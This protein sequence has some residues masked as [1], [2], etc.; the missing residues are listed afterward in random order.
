MIAIW[1][2]FSV[3]V[4]VQCDLR[5]FSGDCC[6]W[7]AM[8]GEGTGQDAGGHSWFPYILK[9]SFMQLVF[10]FVLARPSIVLNGRRGLN[11][12]E[13]QILYQICTY[14]LFYSGSKD[15]I[16]QFNKSSQNKSTTGW[17]IS[18]ITLH[19]SCQSLEIYLFDFPAKSLASSTTGRRRLRSGLTGRAFRVHIHI[20]NYHVLW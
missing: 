9:L 18:L 14:I 7:E 4:S 5:W 11:W 16:L 13:W 15:H 20:L 19:F 8:G 3:C 17:I 10:T 2:P 1:A 12:K 6:G